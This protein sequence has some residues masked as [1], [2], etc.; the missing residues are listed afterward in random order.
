MIG[1]YKIENKINHKVYIGQSQNIERRWSNHVS[2][3]G[4]MKYKMSQALGEFG[5]EN[6][7][8][9]V[10]EECPIE[11]L[12]EREI[13]W[14]KYYNSM[15]PNG[16]NMIEGGNSPRG[17]ANPNVKYSTELIYEIRKRVFIDNEEPSEVFEDYKD[18]FG[19]TYFYHILHGDFRKEANSG[20]ELVRSLINKAGSHNGRATITEEDV[21]SIRKKVYEENIP[22]NQVYLD[23]K[24]IISYSAFQKAAIG[25]TWTNVDT[26]MIKER[27]PERKNKPKAK[28]S[29]E[30]VGIIRYRHDILGESTSEIYKDYC[31][32]VTLNSVKRVIEYKTWKDVKPVSTIPKA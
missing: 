32:K 21:L 23:Y 10:I 27:K 26:S 13:Y 12:D 25:Q 18:I 9:E 28:L 19:R 4:K 6:F 1:I 30:D 22:T 16:Y 11:L 14:I 24:D 31:D 29:K 8:F 5:V 7:S 15:V 2:S 3:A 17:E 20:I